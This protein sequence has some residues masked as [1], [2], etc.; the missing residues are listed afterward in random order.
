M[1]QIIDNVEFDRH[2]IE[3]NIPLEQKFDIETQY[4]VALRNYTLRRFE[5]MNEGIRS[6]IDNPKHN[7]SVMLLNEA[8]QWLDRYEGKYVIRWT[9]LTSELVE[10]FKTE[11]EVIVEYGFTSTSA[12]PGFTM[13]GKDYRLVIEHLNGRYI[14]PFSEYQWEEEVLIPAP[15]FY[16]VEEFNEEERYA[17]LKQIDPNDLDTQEGSNNDI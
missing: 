13:G 15:S 4:K 12:D 1:L 11:D 16:I 14:K 2:L 7:R 8:L 6:G 9:N 5:D 17:V 10:K 3:L